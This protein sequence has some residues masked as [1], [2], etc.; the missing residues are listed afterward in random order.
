MPTVVNGIGTWNYGK[1]NIHRR[2]GVCDFCQ[3][4]GTLTSYDTTRYFVFLFVP[5][6]ALGRKRVIEHCPHCQRFREMSI[7]EWERLR[8]EDMGGALRAFRDDRQNRDKAI[9]ALGKTLA[10]Q[11]KDAFEKVLPYARE[12]FPQDVEILRL[13]AD[14][15][16]YFGMHKQAAKCYRDAVEIA[17]ED[18]ETREAYAVHLLHD[19][20][21]KEAA[22]HLSHLLAEPPSDEKLGLLV[23]LVE[24]YQTVG[25]H[26]DALEVLAKITELR[27]EVAE[28]R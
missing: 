9:A 26:K 23:L 15:Y 28:E 14:G 21:P 7:R 6:F 4:H 11:D 5:L 3:Q 1:R 10:F 20:N 2:Q 22:I 27:P 13:M 16:N 25:G 18:T 12:A 19:L 17:P 8:K 24:G